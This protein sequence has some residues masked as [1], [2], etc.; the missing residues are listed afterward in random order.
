MAVDRCPI[1]QMVLDVGEPAFLRLARLF[2]AETRDAVVE[3]RRRLAIADWREL[4][5]QAHS[6]KHATASFGLTEL[7]AA[8]QAVE[9]AADGGDAEAA[10]WSMASL[11]DRTEATIVEFT[12]LIAEIA[13]PA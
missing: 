3:M 5:R 13:R 2:E 11:T 12:A 8:A 9:Q 4:G 10:T 7:A 1:E 6:L